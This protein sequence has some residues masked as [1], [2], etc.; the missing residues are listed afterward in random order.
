MNFFWVPSGFSSTSTTS[1][2]NATLS[3]PVW[4][5]MQKQSRQCSPTRAPRTSAAEHPSQFPLNSHEAHSCCSWPLPCP[6]PAK[7]IQTI[8]H[9]KKVSKHCQKT[10]VQTPRYAFNPPCSPLLIFTSHAGWIQWV[11]NVKLQLLDVL[12]SGSTLFHCHRRLPQPC[13]KNKGVLFFQK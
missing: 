5:L 4:S 12:V 6:T 8:P 13:C 11:Q 2:L 10:S 7:A 1:R 3:F 9:G